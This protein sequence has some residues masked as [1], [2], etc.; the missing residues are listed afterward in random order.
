MLL[1]A[2]QVRGSRTVAAAAGNLVA[3]LTCCTDA[4]ATTT[5]AT[6]AA[7]GLALVILENEEIVRT[8]IDFGA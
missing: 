4:T 1:I 7:L 8:D 3:L 2:L 6:R 5:V